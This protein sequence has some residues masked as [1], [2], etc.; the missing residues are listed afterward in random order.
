[1]TSKPLIIG[2]HGLNNKPE[3]ELLQDWWRAAIDEGLEK[4]ESAT[5]LEFDFE[6]IYWADRLYTHPMHRNEDRFFDDLYINEPYIEAE[7]GRLKTKEDGLLD[8]AIIGAGDIVG[9]TVDILKSKFGFDMLADAVLGK[10]L[11]DLNL[12]YQNEDIRSDLRDRVMQSLRGAESSKIMVVGH[13]M[14]SIIAYDALTLLGRPDPQVDVNHFVTIGSPLGLPHVY[15][16]IV[17]E[18]E[19][20]GEEKDR[21]RTPTVVT[22]RWVNYADRKDPVALDA[23]LRDDFKAN[24][25]GDGVRCEDD[26]VFNDYRITKR[27]AD[28]PDSNHHKS[29]GYLR[30]PEF[31][32]LL[33]EFLRP[34]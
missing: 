23:H 13:S 8:D 31:S 15:N 17:E 1:M 30:T 20:R 14:G 12:Y 16:K 34:A 18:F 5:N 32:K 24:Q 19:H 3:K 33:R 2:I 26:L 11:K 29:Y 25:G 27:G 6:L 10:L 22:G 28:E 7:P 4:N 21:V 9:T